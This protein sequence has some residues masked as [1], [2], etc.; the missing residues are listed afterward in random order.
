MSLIHLLND[1]VN[2]C[3]LGVVIV[4]LYIL[5][6]IAGMLIMRRYLPHQKRKNHNDVAGGIFAVMGCIYAVIL[7]FVVVMTWGNYDKAT[8]IAMNESNCLGILYQNSAAFPA[9]TRQQITEE[10]KSYVNAIIEDEWPIMYK[11]ESGKVRLEQ[12]RLWHTYTSYVPKDDL[13][14]LFLAESVKKL[15]AAFEFRH[16]RIFQAREVVHPVIYFVLIFGGLM[17]IAFTF[18]FGTENFVP[19]LILISILSVMIGLAIFTIIV[20]DSPYTGPLGVQP[21]MFRTILKS[22]SMAAG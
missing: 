10:L 9:D 21:D 11:G 18:F 22:M 2:V 13:Q 17:T 8:Q 7:A 12:N 14:K 16:E 3:V 1:N 20:L 6:V 5:L 15:N 4:A 19:Q